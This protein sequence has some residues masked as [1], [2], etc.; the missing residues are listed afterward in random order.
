LDAELV[1][2]G[3]K[4]STTVLVTGLLAPPGEVFRILQS[5]GILAGSGDSNALEAVYDDAAIADPVDRNQNPSC[6]AGLPTSDP[7]EVMG[8]VR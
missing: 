8:S 5:A 2:L 3:S 4:P 7:A 6:A 1:R